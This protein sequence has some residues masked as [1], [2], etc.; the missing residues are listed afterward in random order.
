MRSVLLLCSILFIATAVT[1]QT[2]MIKKVELAGENIIVHYELEDATPNREYLL[3]LYSSFNSFSTPMTKVTGDVGQE[4]Q[5]GVNKKMIWNVR[6][7]LGGYKGKLSLEIRGRAYTPFVKLQNFETQK[8]YKRGKRY[9]ITWKAGGTNP[10]HLEL[11]HGDKRIQGEMN[12]PNNGVYT[13]SIPPKTKPGKDYRLRISDSKNSDEIVYTPYFKIA[14]KV[15]PI[16]KYG[17]TAVVV[18]G[19]VYFLFIPPPE[20]GIEDPPFPT[21]N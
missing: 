10:I 17:V 18:G 19:V 21:R 16:I 14:P 8:A 9:N 11:F 3:H 15:S 13:L 4:I 12:H 2:V 1:A 6:S 20:T 5:P 7:E